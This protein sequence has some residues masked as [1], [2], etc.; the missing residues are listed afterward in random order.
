MDCGAL[1]LLVTPRESRRL[2]GAGQWRQST[3]ARAVEFANLVEK[4][5]AQCGLGEARLDGGAGDRRRSSSSLRPKCSRATAYSPPTLA[6]KYG[7]SSEP[8]V[9]RTPASRRTGKRVLLVAGEDARGRRWTSGTP[10]ARSAALGELGDE[11][12]VL[13]RAH[14]VADPRDA[15]ARARRAPSPAPAHSPAWT[16]AARGPR[17]PRSRRPRRRARA[18]SRP[19]RRPARSRRRRGAAAPAVCSAISIGAARRRSCARATLRMR[20]SMPWSRRASSIPA[21]MP[22]QC[23]SSVEPG[24]PR[25]VGRGGQLDVDRALARRTTR[26]TR[27]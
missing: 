3:A 4:V 13:D 17:R 5:V 23:S 16:R 20:A 2:P 27:R 10:R 22:A 26:G 25:V 11:R 15:A 7:G 12:R 8:S 1:L 18:G 19:R 9:T 6:P 14:A 21:A 24:Q